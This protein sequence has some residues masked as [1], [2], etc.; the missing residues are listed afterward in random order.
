MK[1]EIKEIKQLIQKEKTTVVKNDNNDQISEEES[2][3]QSSSIDG[4][5]DEE[6]MVRVEA[7]I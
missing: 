3:I 4:G 1:S 5:R 6:A 7:K 2:E